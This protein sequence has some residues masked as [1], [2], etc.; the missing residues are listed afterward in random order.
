VLF[1]KKGE[2]SNPANYRPIALHVTTYK[3]WTSIITQTLQVYAE[4]AKLISSAQ[5][6]FRK[7]RSC[8]RQLQ[9]LTSVVE[10]AKLSKRNV[11]LLKVDFPSAISS[12]DHARLSTS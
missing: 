12:I 9:L 7:Y 1:H 6:G 3:L 10:D 8:E 4:E 5:E 11:F 2:V